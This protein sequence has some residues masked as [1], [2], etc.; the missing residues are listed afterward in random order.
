M[1]LEL[2][3]RVLVQNS[4]H[5]VLNLHQGL[6]LGGFEFSVNAMWTGNGTWA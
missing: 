6:V 5:T 4:L 3:L 2:L 1:T